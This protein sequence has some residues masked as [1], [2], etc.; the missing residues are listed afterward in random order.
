MTLDGDQQTRRGRTTF[1]HLLSGGLLTGLLIGLGATGYAWACGWRPGPPG[2]EGRPRAVPGPALVDL[3]RVPG[4]RPLQAAW[5]VGNQG[6]RRLI[7]ARQASDCGCL[8]GDAE[9]IV[10]PGRRR[11]LHVTLDP[12]Q[13]VGAIAVPVRYQTNDPRQPVVEFQVRAEVVRDEPSP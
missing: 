9:V 1:A 7:L 12:R 3:G 13:F 8:S 11:D 2:S 10:A 6:G 4:E 5:T